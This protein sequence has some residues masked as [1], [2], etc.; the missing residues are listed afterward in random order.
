VTYGHE[1]NIY[2]HAITPLE[3]FFKIAT[4]LYSHP[5]ATDYIAEVPALD[6]VFKDDSMPVVFGAQAT[7]VEEFINHC[8]RWYTYNATSFS[9]VFEGD[10]FIFAVNERAKVKNISRLA[11]EPVNRICGHEIPPP[12]VELPK[13][14]L[15]TDSETAEGTIRLTGCPWRPNNYQSDTANDIAHYEKTGALEWMTRS[16]DFFKRRQDEVSSIAD[17]ASASERET[18]TMS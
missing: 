12:G 1:G 14:L 18:C 2:S 8:Y 13:N 5:D 11:H 7:L 10:A 16:I 4:I 9:S 3:D 6:E 15:L 17:T